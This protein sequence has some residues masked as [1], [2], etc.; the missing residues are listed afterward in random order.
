MWTLPEAT[1]VAKPNERRGEVTQLTAEDC[2][3]A[4]VFFISHPPKKFLIG[5]LLSVKLK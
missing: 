1:E 5:H 4:K 3:S 2:N